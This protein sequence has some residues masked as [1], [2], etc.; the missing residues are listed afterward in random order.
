M[1][2]PRQLD[3]GSAGHQ[4]AVGGGAA[5]Q[6]SVYLVVKGFGKV[7]DCLLPGQSGNLRGEWRG[8]AVWGWGSL[9]SVF[10]PS[11]WI[12]NFVSQQLQA[13][14]WS[15]EMRTGLGTQRGNQEGGGGGG[16]ILLG[17]SI[18][19][20]LGRCRFPFRFAGK[21]SEWGDH[22]LSAS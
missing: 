1:P 8:A 15:E 9:F 5:R 19:K 4:L 7:W 13:R 20:S 16:A 2:R 11:S 3:P 6:A 22:Q 10:F 17:E 14:C 18:G 12:P 21:S